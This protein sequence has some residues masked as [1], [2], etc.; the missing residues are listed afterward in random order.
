ML[1]VI[2]R[3]TTTRFRFTS[4]MNTRMF[5]YATCAGV[6][7]LALVTLLALNV[8]TRKAESRSLVTVSAADRARPYFNFQDGR[9]VSV[10]Y[11]G[12]DLAVQDLR[13]GEA[14]PRA[15]A[16]A[17][18]DGNATPDVV[19]GYAAGGKG[20]VT[21]QRGSPEAFA[22]LDD[23]VFA[24]MQQGY[25]PAALLPEAE[26]YQ[27][28][29]PA[30]FIAAGDFNHD[31]RKDV[32]VATRGGGMYLLSGDGH[33][34]LSDAEKIDLPGTVTTLA[35]GE[36][37]AA[38]GSPEV[39]VGVRGA[40]PQLLIYDGAEG[41]VTAK[42]MEM[43][44]RNDATA[45]Q[46]GRA[47]TDPFMD[48]FVAAGS[49]IEIVHGWG[50]K[51]SPTLESQREHVSASSVVQ[52]LTVGHFVWERERRQEIA[53]LSSD[54][55]V[56]ILQPNGV[57]TK[58][59]N[60][61]ELFKR[62][63][64][65][66]RPETNI[67][68]NVE[69]EPGWK[70][71]GRSGWNV[72]RTV[73]TSAAA[74]D[75][76]GQARLTTTNVASRE[77]EEV[78]VAGTRNQLTLMRQID[79]EVGDK[80]TAQGVAVSAS[81]DMAE[82]NLPATDSPVAVLQ[83]PSKLNGERDLVVLQAGSPAPNIVPLAPTSIT[84][85]TTTD[86]AALSACTG[87]AGDCSL[88]GAIT[89]ANIAGNSPATITV[90]AGTYVLSI[91]GSSSVGCDANNVGDL[92]INLST[93][94]NGA[95][96]ATTIIRQAGTGV[97]GATP[98]DRIACLNINFLPNLT[99]NFSGL[100]M[101]GGRDYSN[102]GGAVI[103]GEDNNNVNFT[104]C[105]IANNQGFDVALGGG[106]GGG[107][108]I[109]GGNLT[110]T[111][112]TIGGTTTQATTPGAD[113][114]ST[115]L[116]NTGARSGGGVSYATGCPSGVN[117]CVGTFTSTNT[118]YTHNAAASATNGGGGLD[119]YAINLGTG[120]ANINGSTFSNNSVTASGGGLIV[121]STLVTT[122]TTS[123]FSNN[124]A[125]SRGGGLSVAGGT[126][127][128]DGTAAPGVTFSGNTATTAASSLV[129]NA[130]VTVSGTNFSIDG[131][132]DVGANGTLTT[133]ASSTWSLT[134]LNVYGTM[135]HNGTGLNISGNLL[136]GPESAGVHGGIFNVGS[137]T[138][139]L[140]GNLT[141]INSTLANPNNTQFNGS[142][143]TF[144]FTG[145]GAQS[146]CSGTPTC[147][148]GVIGTT[149][150]NFG[151]L[152]VNKG[153]NSTLTANL[154]ASVAGDLTVTA[155][156]F[157][158]QANTF[159]RTVNGGTLTVSNG[160]TLKIG[161]TNA[162]PTNFSTHSIG[163]TSTIEY[164]GTNQTV[165]TLNSSQNYG[166]LTLSGS[167]TKSLQAAFN[168]LGN[169]TI[170]GTA[171]LDATASNFNLD[172]AGNWTNNV[173]AA[174]F[175]PRAATVTFSSASAGQSINGTATSQT[176]N[177]LV[178]SKSGQTLSV[179]GSTATLTLNGG[180]T[181]GAGTFAAGTATNINI[182]GNWTNNVG[183]AAF[184]PG[185]GTVTFNSTTDAQSIN[186]TAASQTF[187]NLTVS[188]TGQTLSTG[189]STTQLDL[190]GTFNLTAGTFTAPTTMNVGGDWTRATGT[191][192]NTSSGIV[193]F[194]GSGARNLNGTAASQT[195]NNVE[196]AK[197]GG[198][199]VTVGGSTTTFSLV[200]MTLTSGTFV[201]G[202][203]S[204]INVTG[205]WTNN[206]G[207]FNPTTGTV[208][209]NNGAAGQAINGTAVSQSF[210]GLTV[211]KGAQTLSVGGS[212][213]TLDINGSLT[214]TTGTLT[215]PTTITLAGNFDQA[216]GTTFTP[217]AGT[218]TFDGAGAQNIQGTL[219]TKIFNNF[220]VN[221]GGNTLTSI[222]GTT[223]LDINGNLTITAGTFAAGTAANINVF[224]DWT[225]N[226]TFTAGT[227]TVIFDGDNNTQTISG[228]SVS[229][230][231]NLTSMHT[232]TG[233][234]TLGA[235]ITVNGV[236]TLTS[237]IDA[238]SSTLTMPATGTS[239]GTGDVIGN[240][241]RTGFISG[242]GANTL[243][244]GN[245]DNRITINSG[246][247]PTD[248]TINLVKAAPSGGIAFPTAVE[249]TYTITPTSGSG[250]SATLRLHYLDAELNGNTEVGLG[251]WRYNGA[252]W[253]RQG[254]SAADTMANW[255][256]LNNIAQFSPWTLSSAKND[257]TTTITADTPDPSLV[258]QAVPINFSV[259]SN[260]GGA[261]TPTGSVTITVNDASGD[262]CM[263]S[264]SGGTGSCNLTLTTVGAKTLTATYS[265]DSNFNAS[266]DTEPHQVVQGTVVV[267][268]ASVAEPTSGT[269]NML[270]TVTLSSPALGGESVDFT[271]ADQVPGPGQAVAGTCGNPGADY[272]T[273]SGTASFSA[274]Q[275]VK[276]IAVPVC[277]DADN[278]EPDETFLLNLS[279]PQGGVIITDNQA[280]GTIKTA[281]T[282][283]TFLISE[284]RTR[285]TAGAGDD[286]V[287]LYNNTDSPLTVAASDASAGYG[288]YK[289]GTTCDDTPVLIATIP[290]ST[291]IPARG[292]YL[293]VGSAYSLA[294]YGG[295][296]AAAGNV[297]LTL[298]IEDDH[299]VAVFSTANVLNISSA[300]RL[301]AV[302]FGM[303]TG[304]VCD[305]LR[306]GTNQGAVGAMNIEDSFFRKLFSGN[307]QDTNDN[308]VDFLFAD[309]VATPIAGLTQ[310]LG[311]PGPENLASPLRRDNTGILLPLLDGTVSSSQAP[312]RFRNF[313]NIVPNGPN[314][315]LDIR[316]RVQNTTGATVT[317]LRFRIVDMT[318]GPTPP[319]GTADLRAITSSAVAISGIND[320][321]TCASTG[322]PATVPCQVTA[323]ATV[324]ETPPAQTNGGGY[325]STVTVSIP[326][327]LANNAS[328]DVNFQLGVM[329]AGTFRFKII[330]EALP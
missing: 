84:V 222:A 111:G 315:T 17:D 281:N 316:R 272:E 37:R 198:G 141:L 305:L 63:R 19:V 203:A 186:G 110:I 85:D 329:Q 197:T 16:S 267:N 8:G 256:E 242:G 59:Y 48:V 265:S 187:N 155:G 246:T 87:A 36:F 31:N 318:T 226:A 163:A 258:G 28:P 72:A 47:D 276:T 301:D 303:N 51:F 61:T 243:S 278:T 280:I 285:G 18:M 234:V 277:S 196:I 213:T 231:N 184:T 96:A 215:A 14:Q 177:N 134:N 314:G 108:L 6:A 208:F 116:G 21:I 25:N 1:R 55:T 133:N 297:T 214:L 65:H 41:G 319:A 64:A 43:F 310:R 118:T 304:S 44:L 245:P 132:V 143:S 86:N 30:D 206:G 323:Q 176:F 255:V 275:Q 257:S 159:N 201:N 24:R 89:F 220:T 75:I 205:D 261:P 13:S 71:A 104:N 260:V 179:G 73:A 227:G 247:V 142:S 252:A 298:D 127:A 165:V 290:N 221:K 95:G 182:A 207:T 27:V 52:G 115:T 57:N 22:P 236:L 279:N 79:P 137:G 200:N 146:I 20:I 189:G 98:G 223:A 150:F 113:R 103:G 124:S 42:P 190:N 263:G 5:R 39:V 248:I 125:G 167:G 210:F 327:G 81:G 112:S 126:V 90:P 225:N 193:T 317:R 291:V 99:Y 217:G 296:G 287:E 130:P 302:G 180:L 172:V 10:D 78:V 195:F 306:E 250:I 91:N 299:N 93:T 199:S 38:D 273:T 76:P 229:P 241:K 62:N 169:V 117:G 311:A 9:A 228:S 7:L 70:P 114:T 120:S 269:T 324:L 313:V 274:G 330:V 270:F 288:V 283:G 11:R 188:K 60:D 183:A 309:T 251:L 148:S 266:D 292:H 26:S 54:G 300:N 328:I 174:N 164:E 2:A 154:G 102:S 58:R 46:F 158:L 262:T 94:I 32:L 254:S 105:V 157:D 289:M 67:N 202:T 235:N 50:R 161:G 33:G 271:T 312:N 232:N 282:A 230:F 97:G 191:T 320:P 77:I 129:A 66:V 56:S 325:N 109:Q 119:F 160:T 178:V 101:V 45:V 135:T 122:I 152:T 238:G 92:Q 286:F 107:I 249:R 185:S 194:N 204:T 212:T 166:N 253:A 170:N 49:G 239:A 82:V 144:N 259:T 308:S 139:N 233:G 83:L 131:S 284:L 12:Q 128:L 138:V 68:Q 295:T 34:G 307:P 321:A 326:G 218:V 145:S 264:L 219:V 100:T 322:T 121:E 15:I 244:F 106:G 123:T 168:I 136:L 88:R 53:V 181:I 3:T 293:A 80:T 147:N 74:A 151:T 192:F 216:T 162:V 294:D 240:V 40:G 224:G 173:A 153:S 140:Q 4:S 237:D 69:A 23:S 268:D 29:E 175:N 211:A 156:I 171:T 209:F 35:T 149:V